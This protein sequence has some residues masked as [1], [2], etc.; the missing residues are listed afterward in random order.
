[1]K[2]DNFKSFLDSKKC[3]KII[4]G[5]GNKYY[6]EITN[7]CALYAVAGCRFFDVNPS[8]EA[9]QAAKAGFKYAGKEKECF[10]CVSVGT[11]DDP[12]FMKCDIDSNKCSACGACE[13]ACMQQAVKTKTGTY[14]IEKDK[15]IGCQKCRT[16]C[17]SSAIN[18]YRDEMSL[19]DTILPLLKEDFDCLEYHIITDSET[20]IMNGWKNIISMYNGPI[21]VCLDRSKFGNEQVVKCLKKMKSSCN[22]IFIVQADGAPMSGG[23]D[24]YRTTLQA[25]S[26][27]DI[28][29]KAN[30]TP[31]IF[32]SGGT[33][34]K[35]KELLK[36]CNIDVT[37]ISIGSFARKNVKEYIENDS[38]LTD[39]GI[40]NKALALAKRII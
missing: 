12:H 32:I 8:V 31:Y 16:A 33:N 30:I 14:Y 3:F 11:N 39:K 19:S 9:I 15:C 35:T 27:A 26:M 38:F 21:S 7:L 20:E 1:M 4:C 28:I 37:G 17:K 36:L 23:E 2:N 10:I 6:N 25:V 18:T 5:A 29:D 13:K 40:F 24:D 22:D 34:S